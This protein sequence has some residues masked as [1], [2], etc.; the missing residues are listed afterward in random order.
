MYISVLKTNLNLDRDLNRD[1]VGP[2]KVKIQNAI[3]IP[4]VRFIK[5]RIGENGLSQKSATEVFFFKPK[6]CFNFIFS[7]TLRAMPGTLS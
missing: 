1:W 7:L 3:K 5:G 6:Q 4:T 2:M